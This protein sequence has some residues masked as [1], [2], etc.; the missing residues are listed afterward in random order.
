ME[1]P[2]LI[3]KLDW[4]FL[5][6]SNPDGYIYNTPFLNKCVNDFRKMWRKNRQPS[7]N[8]SS[9]IG[10]D[11]NRN[12]DF[13]MQNIRVEQ[14]WKGNDVAFMK[15]NSEIENHCE[16]SFEGLTPF[17]APET[18]N[19]Q[20]FILNYKDN[21]KFFNTIHCC[22]QILLMPWASTR[23]PVTN[24]EMIDYFAQKAV[25]EIAQHHHAELI[26][27][28]IR[29]K[30]ADMLMTEIA[31]IHQNKVIVCTNSQYLKHSECKK[32]Y[33]GSD[34]PFYRSIS[35]F[36][37]LFIGI[38]NRFGSIDRPVNIDNIPNRDVL[39]K[40]LA[41]RL[42]NDDAIVVRKGSVY[43][44]IMSSDRSIRILE[45]IDSFNILPDLIK[46]VY[47]R[48]YEVGPVVP[49]FSKDA[50]IGTSMDWAYGVAKIPYTFTLE[51]PYNRRKRYAMPSEQY[52]T[53]SGKEIWA[54]HKS[55]A[56]QIIAEYN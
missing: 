46:N 33:N 22:A 41:S 3:E 16:N 39:F 34:V 14:V 56:R 23:V 26:Q 13:D 19:M 47:Q 10:T 52:I 1:H 11:L 24:I 29:Q 37:T 44:G 36:D 15:R 20:N 12:W 31:I 32:E 54:F 8:N 21:I 42:N 7:G 18:R 40:Y 55:A 51:L 35:P 4:Y 38:G 9:C 28:L 49:K 2:E 43:L 17:S 27:E 48:T 5:P 50:I 45:N 6:V 25:N 53:T 30:V